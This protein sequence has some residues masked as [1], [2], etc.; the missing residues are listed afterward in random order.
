MG[1]CLNAG[2]SGLEER[3]SCQKGAG[4][5]GGQDNKQNYH[6]HERKPI[7]TLEKQKRTGTSQVDRTGFHFLRC[8]QTSPGE[9][10]KKNK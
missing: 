7:S 8:A 10:G 3:K 9:K 6:Q 2:K 4:D 1:C 5:T